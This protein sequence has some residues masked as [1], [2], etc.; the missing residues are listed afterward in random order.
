[1]T[2]R[3]NS[4]NLPIERPFIFYVNERE[5]VTIMA[6]PDNLDELAAGWLWANDLISGAAE[7]SRIMIDVERSI[8]WTE[9][10]GDVPQ[11]FRRT[12]S[13]GCGG[14]A[15][16]ADLSA[17]LAHVVSPINLAMPALGVLMDD[18][19][20]RATLYKKTGGVHGAAIATTK[21]VEFVAEDIG[22][23]NAVDKVIGWA[24]LGDISLV[25]KLIL[26]TG[27][28]SS[29]MMLKSAKAGFPIVASRTAATDLAVKL[30]NEAG[31]T[32]AG[33]VRK[34]AAVVYS[35]GERLMETES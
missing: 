35:H 7:I 13:S 10:T 25:D 31:I 6:S 1:M 19:F 3:R 27:R 8:I 12:I 32:L 14:G 28:I 33:Y 30:A 17:K 23:H 20:S 9:I 2:G 5:I 21:S 15:L 4:E 16:I 22:R 34:D 24:L 26:T 18:F 29:E 11:T